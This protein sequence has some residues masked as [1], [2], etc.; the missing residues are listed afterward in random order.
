[1]FQMNQ[2]PNYNG[3]EWFCSHFSATIQVAEI[4]HDIYWRDF[5]QMLRWR[6]KFEEVEQTFSKSGTKIDNDSLSLRVQLDQIPTYCLI[7]T[8]AS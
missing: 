6:D 7:A 5:E 1:M 4:R 3:L 8:Q 2:K